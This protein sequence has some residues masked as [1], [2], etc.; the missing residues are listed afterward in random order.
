M[1]F[2]FGIATVTAGSA[3][4]VMSSPP[5][6]APRVCVCGSARERIAR[7]TSF[8][9]GIGK[10]SLLHFASVLSVHFGFS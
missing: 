7:R 8:H 9:S 2:A 1:Q 3:V 5:P 10:F 6:T 4:G